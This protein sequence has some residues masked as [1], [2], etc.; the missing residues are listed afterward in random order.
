M[1]TIQSFWVGKIGVM[2]RLS[3]TSYVKNDHPYHLYTYGK[4]EGV[5]AGVELRDASDIIPESDTQLFRYPAHFADWFRFNLLLKCGGWWVDTDTVCLKP[6]VFDDDYVVIEEIMPNNSLAVVEAFFRPQ[7]FTAVND[8]LK[9]GVPFVS[10]GYLK[11]PKNSPIIRWVIDRCLEIKSEWKTMPWATL[12]P[13]M[14]WRAVQHFGLKVLNAEVLAP[15]PGYL[16]EKFVEENYPF[17]KKSSAIHLWHSGWAAHNMNPDGEYPPTSIYEKLKE[18]YMD[19]FKVVIPS[20]TD[21]NLLQCI[22]A[23]KE[24]EPGLTKNDII[25]VEDGSRTPLTEHLDVTWITGIKPFIYSRN[26]NLGIALAQSN[27]IVLND[28]TRLTTYHGFTNMM[29]TAL[30]NPE[31]G[32]I[33]PALSRSWAVGEMRQTES[34]LRAVDTLLSFVCV[35]IPYETQQRI[36][37]LDEQFVG[38]GWEDW[39][40][41]RRCVLAGL[42]LGVYD[43]TVL[44]HHILPST[45]RQGK[46]SKNYNALEL[47]NRIL[48]EKKWQAHASVEVFTRLQSSGIEA[49]KII[50]GHMH[51]AGLKWLSKT[52]AG[53]SLVV[54]LGSFRGRSTKALADSGAGHVIA[55]DDFSIPSDLE[56]FK[57]N[58]KDAIIGGTV[59]VWKTDFRD[60]ARLE[61]L[62]AGRKPDMI[63][64]DGDTPYEEL[65][66]NFEFWLPRLESGCTVC[67]SDFLL[68]GVQ[69]AMNKFLGLET[70]E[71]IEVSEDHRTWS[72]VKVGDRYIYP[73]SLETI[74]ALWVGGFLGTIELLC[75]RSYTA[76]SHPFDLYT[77]QPIKN[78]P[79]GVNVRDAN[80]IVPEY[81]V[82]RFN[83]MAQFSDW[84]RYHLIN[85][86]G[87]WYVDMDTVCVRPFIFPYDPIVVGEEDAGVDRLTL[88]LP[89]Y[90]NG[91]AF[92]A[93][94]G[95]EFIKWL[96]EESGKKNWATMR[97][98]DTGPTLLT[99]A[100]L[101]FNVPWKSIYMFNPIPAH[102]FK[103]LTDVTPRLFT[104]DTYSIHLYRAMWK[105]FQPQDPD[106]KY[107]HTSL[108]ETLKRKHY[109]VE[110]VESVRKACI[111]TP[112]IQQGITTP[113]PK[114]GVVCVI[115]NGKRVWLDSKGNL[116]V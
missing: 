38:Y 67:G 108:Y 104:P 82:K 47:H 76:H 20:G 95:S 23:I 49:A 77:Y 113:V 80:E 106:A 1:E 52:A 11:F 29:N 18:R 112:P 63:F 22:K 55:V 53:H 86:T 15:V 99:Q 12:T 91:S 68:E 90:I 64:I 54:E 69:T 3:M 73:K 92:K 24:N 111:T 93:P 59:E 78:L 9:I 94:A 60:H 51:E 75:L 84:F 35:C 26:V 13:M 70:L 27:V 39:D 89:V 101:K 21:S 31:Y 45:F 44:E 56:D 48:Y 34:D 43:G 10:S 107:P 83:Y 71:T 66:E 6:L 46:N 40:Y 105:I 97:W 57:E 116:I 33:G 115:R 8:G 17:P 4:P 25:V 65:M 19:K 109:I 36:G 2:E 88:Q 32:V 72:T 58:L 62:L 50:G 28:D 98:C 61:R 5:P 114:L 37:P 30:D 100:V 79:A 14:V 96:V 87:G 7:D 41:D 81:D 103:E 42:K 74:Q 102:A 110:G 16:T 85:K